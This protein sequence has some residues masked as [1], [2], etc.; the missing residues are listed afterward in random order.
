MY[1]GFVLFCQTIWYEMTCIRLLVLMIQFVLLSINAWMFKTLL[2]CHLRYLIVIKIIYI[3][4]LGAGRVTRILGVG[5]G[6]LPR[7]AGEAST[8][9]IAI[10]RGRA[11]ASMIWPRCHP[12]FPQTQMYGIPMDESAEMTHGSWKSEGPWMMRIREGKNP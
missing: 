3:H 6:K 2:H 9:L 10:V 5:L 11:G 4:I 12:Q 8:G 7:H 1:Y